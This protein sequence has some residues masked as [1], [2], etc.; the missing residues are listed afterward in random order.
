[1]STLLDPGQAIKRAFDD[2]S[3]SFKVNVVD[4]S[5]SNQTVI[6][7]LQISYTNINGSGGAVYQIVPSTSALINKLIP[8]EQTGVAISLYTGSSGNEV[9]L[10]KLAPGQ[11]NEVP[12]NIA[13][14]TRLSIRA[15]GASAPVAGATYLTFVG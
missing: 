12:V 7:S 5:A 8:N 15:T 1:M 14:G 9:E 3:Q 4:A 6:Y 11:D 10:L 2:D 13:A